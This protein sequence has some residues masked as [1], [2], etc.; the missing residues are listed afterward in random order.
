MQPYL[1]VRDV[2]QPVVFDVTATVDS[3]SQLSGTATTSVLRSDY[4]LEI[5]N[6]PSVANVSEEVQLEIDFV[7]LAGA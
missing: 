6:V 3:L 5:P 7:A 1:T 4:G 2:T